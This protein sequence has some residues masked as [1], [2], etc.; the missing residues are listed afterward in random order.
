MEASRVWTNAHVALT[1]EFERISGTV[2]ATATGAAWHFD[3]TRHLR[4][5]GVDGDALDCRVI[6]DSLRTDEGEGLSGVVQ[7]GDNTYRISIMLDAGASEVVFGLEPISEVHGIG[8]IVFPGPLLP[9]AG[10]VDQVVLPMMLTNGVVHRSAPDDHWTHSFN[11]ASHSGLNMPFWG[12]QAGTA[13]ALVMLETADDV[14]LTLEK[15]VREPLEVATTW[16]ASLGSLRYAR[17]VR[18]ALLDGGGYVAIAKAYRRYVQR[19]GHFKTLAQKID[20]RP[21][22]QQVIGGPYFSLGYL[23]F[24]ERKF[25]QITRGLRDIG[26]TNGIIGPIDHIQWDSGEWLNDYQPFIKAPHFGKIAADEGF[27]AFSWLY[28]EDILTWDR[29]YDP[30][31]VVRTQDGGMIEGWFNRDYEYQLICAKVLKEKH[32]QLRDEI[33]KFDALHFDTTTSKAL[34]ECW[35][36][37]HP[38][39]KSE[40]RESRRARLAEVA[41]WGRLIGSESG[42]DWAFD[43]YDFCSSNPRR[44]METKLPVPADHVPLLG[45][46]YHES[47]VSYCWEYDPYNKSYFGV[48]WSEDKLLYDVMAG[49][50]P[51]IAPIFGYFPVIRRPAPPVESRWVTWEDPTTQKLLRDALPVAQLHGRTAHVEMTDHTFL[52][53]QRTISRTVYADGTDVVVNTGQSSFEEGGTQVAARSYRIA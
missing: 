27:A 6:K 43:V 16:T 33:V 41:S 13:S 40:D 31:M 12:L 36:P 21:S 10:S 4:A 45:L 14:T 51:T 42:Y 39:S 50:P 35:H 1:V 7:I 28:M 22:V 38:M 49:N 48:D 24:S 25:R 46:V 19:Q 32:A 29:Y 23:P 34:N 11:V 15:S 53:E 18:L 30:E 44:A 5:L 3:V 8:S 2:L 26:Y 52:D 9:L 17:R 37:D 20:E 47:V